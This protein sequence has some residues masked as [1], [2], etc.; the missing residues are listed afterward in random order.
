[1]HVK[2]PDELGDVP[3]SG[4]LICTA[5]LL[6]LGSINP[7]PW[8]MWFLEWPSEEGTWVWDVPVPGMAERLLTLTEVAMM[9]Y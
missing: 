6:T 7:G 1:M 9:Q 4:A 5:W 2:T 3:G 8:C